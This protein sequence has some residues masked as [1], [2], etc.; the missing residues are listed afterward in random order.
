MAKRHHSGTG[1]VS[2]VR[3]CQE[4]LLARTGV[5]EFYETVK[6][7]VAKAIHERSK[8][9]ELLN[10]EL[11][12]QLLELESLNVKRFVEGPA[13]ILAPIDVVNECLNV[14]RP[15]ELESIGFEA[16]DAA[17]EGM[18]SREAKSDKGQ[19]FTP[20]HVIQ[21]CIDVLRPK[22]GE[23]IC[24][25]A[26]GSAAFLHSAYEFLKDDHPEL[27]GFDISQR[28]VNTANLMSYLACGDT[29]NLSQID[30]LQLKNASL[31]WDGSATI[32]DFMLNTGKKFEGYDVIAT[33]P[34]FAGDVST[35]DFISAYETARLSSRKVERDVL[36]MERCVK[37]L[38]PGGRLAIVLP[39]NKVSATQFAPIRRW[40]M[41][42]IN[43]VG[44]VSL[45]AF[46][47]RPYTSQKTAVVFGQKPI[48]GTVAA[49]KINMYRSDKAGKKS[50]GDYLYVDGQIDD[51]LEPIKN[52]L[53]KK[54]NV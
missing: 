26:C 49:N 14:L 51:D 47:F 45:H 27:Y 20:R 18:T 35:A 9:T 48:N 8:R 33:N 12:Q 44:V 17:F 28:A 43:I 38:R 39:D 46:T 24:D 23:A 54:W 2:Q 30:S 7:L 11:A 5:D 1:L 13:E 42:Q 32:E 31:L 4:L 53:V 41:S 52:D 25:P 34:P 22:H 40:L 3:R 16:L 50:N 29:L 6:L 37:L 10:Y 36:F 21:F 15:T 19:F